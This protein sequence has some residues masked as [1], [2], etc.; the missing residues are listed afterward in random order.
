MLPPCS[1]AV[2]SRVPQVD[3]FAFDAQGFLA[4][5]IGGEDFPV[6][7]HVGRALVLG[8]LQGV[9]QVWC[10]PGEHGDDLIQVA[11]A[12]GTGDAV[13]AGQCGDVGVL[14]EPAQAEH[15]V[16]KAGQRPGFL[17]GA[18]LAAFGVQQPAEVQGQFTRHVEH[19]T[20][21]NHGEPSGLDL[22]FANPVL[23]RAPRP[24]SPGLSARRRTRSCSH[25]RFRA[26]QMS[27]DLD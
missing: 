23:P 25:G 20:I 24:S 10:L 21:S 11:V 4:T 7:D 22:I 3:R 1:W 27:R 26:E 9:V 18:A 14:T 17:A 19:G 8:P 16:A 12:G 5:A 6:E 2:L 15:C 13:V